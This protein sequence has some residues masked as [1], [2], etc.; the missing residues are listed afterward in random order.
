MIPRE[1]KVRLAREA[2]ENFRSMNRHCVFLLAGGSL[3]PAL[4][5]KEVH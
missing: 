5:A 4:F 3:N 1:I 2:A